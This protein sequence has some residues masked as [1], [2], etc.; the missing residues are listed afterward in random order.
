MSLTLRTHNINHDSR[1]F[2]QLVAAPPTP[3]PL[4]LNPGQSRSHSLPSICIDSFSDVQDRVGCEELVEE[5]MQDNLSSTPSSSSQKT[6]SSPT[7]SPLYSPSE[8]WNWILDDPIV[9]VDETFLSD[10]AVCSAF[11]NTARVGDK[12]FQYISK[13]WPVLIDWK[14]RFY[15]ELALYKKH[16]KD[17]QGDVV[18]SIITV[19][20]GP[21]TLNVAMEPPHHSFWIEASSDMPLVLKDRCV[22]AFEKLHARGVLHGD[23]ELRHMLIGGDGKVTIIDFQQSRA[24]E[25]ILDVRL[26]RAT[27]AELRKE[28]RKVKVKLDYPGARDLEYRKFQ[29]H[30]RR[31]QANTGSPFSV[32]QMKEDAL[33]P[34]I[35]HQ[36]EWEEWV[37][38]RPL[39]K[40]FVMPGQDPIIF[41]EALQNFLDNV[42][43]R[44]TNFSTTRQASTS[45]RI[46][47]SM[48][49]AI[50]DSIG[51]RTRKRSMEEGES[52]GVPSPPKR[53]RIDDLAMAHA[54]EL[55]PGTTTRTL[56]RTYSDAFSFRPATSSSQPPPSSKRPRSCDNTKQFNT[57]ADS[58][59][60]PGTP[61]SVGITEFLEFPQ[62]QYPH[63]LYF[64]QRRRNSPSTDAVAMQN[65]AACALEQ[66]PHP[67]LV[68]LFPTHPRWQETDVRAFLAARDRKLEQTIRNALHF[69]DRTFCLPREIRSRGNLKREIHGIR[70]RL[71]Y[72]PPT[73][74][75]VLTDISTRTDLH[76]SLSGKVRFSVDDQGC[77]L[78]SPELA[79]A[80]GERDKGLDNASVCPTPGTE[81]LQRHLLLYRPFL[82]WVGSVF[83]WWS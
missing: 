56:K 69:P 76:P 7:F 54:S 31:R 68:E 58:H 81:G 6:A 65:L 5:E 59:T 9:D 22:E 52:S 30:Q 66:L 13:R 67:T 47:L 1:F 63:N 27:P 77:A 72:S 64:P 53:A 19:L 57:T 50:S 28:M 42:D 21:A 11:L 71:G 43:P 12:Q 62:T 40:R 74:P 36:Q 44:G 51:P 2:Q 49:E 83:D 38:E 55:A 78:E 35:R 15:S 79:R 46:P 23:V 39:P 33:N 17:L 14:G 26:E 45:H 34:P 4:V 73:S 25:P 8:R 3:S 29:R 16:M 41:S 20:D 48:S 61:H 10:G 70:Q 37:E 32:S 18:P 75:S 80:A 82:S 24:L 60:T